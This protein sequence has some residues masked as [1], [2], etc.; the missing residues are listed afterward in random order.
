[1]IAEVETTKGTAA[2]TS[3]RW[4]LVHSR[5]VGKG[6]TRPFVR[7]IYSEHEDHASCRNAAKELRKKLASESAGVPPEERDEVFVRRPNF[8]SLKR[9]K[10]RG[11]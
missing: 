6:G 10:A 11:A 1:M 3:D 9:A 2:I 7:S 4:H 5:W 8:K